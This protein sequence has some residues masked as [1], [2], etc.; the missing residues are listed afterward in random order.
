M[1]EYRP[2]RD[3]TGP[4]LRTLAAALGPAYVRVSGT[5]ANTT[6]FADTDNPPATPPGGFKGVL[7][8][9]QWRGVVDFA[10]DTGAKIVSSFAV[11]PGVRDASGRWTPEQAQRWLDF[12]RSIGGEIAVAEFMN[13]PNAAAMGGAPDGYTAADYGRDFRAFKAFIDQAD[14][15]MTV[16]GPGSLGEA[17]AGFGADTTQLADLLATAGMIPT[18]DLLAAAG[19]GV[20]G[21]SYHHYNAASRRCCGAN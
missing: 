4:R 5:W 19:P 1:Y 17:P 18:A 16:L 14:P 2:P 21:F 15:N 12:T 8:R 7:T 10:D 3:L 6:Y 13:E 11:S 9:D 20:D